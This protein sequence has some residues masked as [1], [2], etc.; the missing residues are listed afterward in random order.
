MQQLTKPENL[1]GELVVNV[2]LTNQNVKTIHEA[3]VLMTREGKN[4]EE[5]TVK[6]ASTLREEF[7][8]LHRLFNPS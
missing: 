4:P 1:N 6:L 5:S 2:R 3:L 7:K 8:E